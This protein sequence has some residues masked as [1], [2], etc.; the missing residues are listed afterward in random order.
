MTSLLLGPVPF[1]ESSAHFFTL[2]DFLPTTLFWDPLSTAGRVEVAPCA[3]RVS[4]WSGFRA[5]KVSRRL[6]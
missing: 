6:G 2:A 5:A 1:P 3:S 4:D